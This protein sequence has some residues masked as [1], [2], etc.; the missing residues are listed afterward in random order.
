LAIYNGQLYLSSDKGTNTFKGIDT[1]G[2][3]LPTTGGQTVSRLPGLTD[4]S[5]PSDFSFFMADLDPNVSGLD[6]MYIADDDKNAGG[7]FKYSL[8]N[9]NWVL[10]GS[11]AVG[12][13]NKYRGLTGTVSGSTV[14]L[15]ATRK[16]G[17]DVTGGG[18]LA[19]IV[20]TNG[21]NASISGSFNLIATA[22]ANT[23]F[24][25]VAFVP[26]PEPSASIMLFSSFSAGLMYLWLR[27][28]KYT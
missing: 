9:G 24:R 2:S 1:V 13:N 11:K 4:T 8:V 7:L 12:N 19:S 6:T 3:G 14:T 23:A 26:V 27:R 18:E 21:Y 17:S 28:K 20:D 22:V 25:G 10:T 5:D 15:Y 16:G